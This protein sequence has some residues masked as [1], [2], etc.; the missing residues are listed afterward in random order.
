MTWNLCVTC[1]S[2]H[3]AKGWLALDSSL[4]RTYRALIPNYHINR[5]VNTSE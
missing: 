1:Y 5:H 4:R 3:I 2:W